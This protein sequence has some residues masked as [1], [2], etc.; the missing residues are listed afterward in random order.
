MINLLPPIEKEKI[1]SVRKEK[2]IIIFCIFI[3]FFLFYLIFI[4]FSI[5]FYIQSQLETQIIIL[6]EVKQEFE[7][8]EISTLQKEINL[9]NISLTKLNEFYKNKIYFTEILEKI[10]KTL[11]ENIYLNNFSSVFITSEDISEI[12]I[13]ISGFASDR[14]ILFNFKKNLEKESK[15]EEVYF[16]PAN[17]VKSTD[18]DFLVS[19]KIPF[20]I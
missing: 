10:S 12:K 2:I 17:W 15:F 5:K 4:L 7:K 3:L 11:P 1:E 14:D 6:E 20:E 18:I 19:F 9:A 13:S 8:S 16:P